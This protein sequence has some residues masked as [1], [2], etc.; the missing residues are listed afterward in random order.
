MLR[1]LYYGPELVGLNTGDI[2]EMVVSRRA[3]RQSACSRHARFHAV[4]ILGVECCTDSTALPSHAVPTLSCIRSRGAA[5]GRHTGDWRNL[6]ARQQSAG[7]RHARRHAV[8]ILG[9]ECWASSTMPHGHSV[10]AM[11]WTELVGLHMGDIW[12]M[13]SYLDAHA[14]RALVYV[15]RV[16]TR[17]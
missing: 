12:E 5:N 17:S 15:M 2:W 10:P 14:V 3:H 6:R 8:L 13:V 9:V 7:L 11:P 4:L 1:P 16:A